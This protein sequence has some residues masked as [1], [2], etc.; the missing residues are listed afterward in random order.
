MASLERWAAGNRLRLAWSH[1][2]AMAMWSHAKFPYISN[3]LSDRSSFL[4]EATPRLRC[5]VLGR[6]S[7]Q[8]RLAAVWE[9]R[10]LFHNAAEVTLFGL[11]ACLPHASKEVLVLWHPEATLAAAAATENAAAV[12]KFDAEG[13]RSTLDLQCKA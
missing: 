9:Q 10:G 2:R 11:E 12:V 13:S 4:G 7:Q 5:V 8:C 3:T 1:H 6:T